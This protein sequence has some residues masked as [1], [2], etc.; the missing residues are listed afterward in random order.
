MKELVILNGLSNWQ[1]QSCGTISEAMHAGSLEICT[2]SGKVWVR[3]QA[4][5]R[6]L[7]LGHQKKTRIYRGA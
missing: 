5:Y 2:H 1:S 3:Y 4:V 7:S 6:L